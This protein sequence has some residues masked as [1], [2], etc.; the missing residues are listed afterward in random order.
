M[1]I[2]GWPPSHRDLPASGSGVLGLK[3]VYH[4]ANP[5]DNYGPAILLPQP[6]YYWDY[7]Y[8]TVSR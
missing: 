1:Y 7:R 4:H 2:P 5:Q 6:P 8:V 3:A